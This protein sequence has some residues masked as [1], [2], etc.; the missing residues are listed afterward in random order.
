MEVVSTT[1]QIPESVVLG[2]DAQSLFDFNIKSSGLEI[3]NK[4]IRW[5]EQFPLKAR[6][7]TKIRANSVCAIQFTFKQPSSIFRGMESEE[8]TSQGIELSEGFFSKSRKILVKNQSNNDRFLK[9]GQVIG[10]GTST[11]KDEICSIHDYSDEEAEKLIQQM[12]E[13]GQL[14]K[15]DSGDSYKKVR[16]NPDLDDVKKHC[17]TVQ[18][19]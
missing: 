13:K 14:E 12:R 9:K 8:L 1:E 4:T 6:T 10:F 5:K 2:R 11:R 18:L 7:T 15:Q 17:G 19:S 3:N 16:I